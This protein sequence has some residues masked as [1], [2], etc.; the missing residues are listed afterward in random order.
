MLHLTYLQPHVGSLDKPNEASAFIAIILAFLGLADL[1]AASLNEQTSL[2]YWLSNVPVRLTFLF[3]L[4]GYIYMFKDDGIFGSK[5]LL[6][7]SSPGDNLRNSMNFTWAF[8]ETAAW[9]WVS[10]HLSILASCPLLTY[11]RSF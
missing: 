11:I 8:M 4:S 6:R 1:T 5:S 7:Q 2:E 3:G 10:Q 9:F